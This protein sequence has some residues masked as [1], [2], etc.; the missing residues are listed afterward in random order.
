MDLKYF[1]LNGNLIQSI[2]NGIAS[3]VIKHKLKDSLDIKIIKNRFI[4]LAKRIY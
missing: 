3:I 4:D 1:N 2:R